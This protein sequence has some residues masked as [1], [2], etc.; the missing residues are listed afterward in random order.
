ME[1][2]WFLGTRYTGITSEFN[3]RNK[4]NEPKVKDTYKRGVTNLGG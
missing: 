4:N 2:K 1:S 3:K